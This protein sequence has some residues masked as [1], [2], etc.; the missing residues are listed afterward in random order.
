MMLQIVITANLYNFILETNLSHDPETGSN[1]RKRNVARELTSAFEKKNVI[2][3]IF[4]WAV[5]DAWEEK[6]IHCLAKRHH[7]QQSVCVSQHHQGIELPSQIQNQVH[8]SNTL[9]QLSDSLI[10][11]WYKPLH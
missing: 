2:C 4:T 8:A 7:F 10:T 1:F 3:L 5:S 11:F 9:A 6:R